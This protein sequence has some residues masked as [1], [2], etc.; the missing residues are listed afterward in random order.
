M[1]LS[2]GQI[3]KLIFCPLNWA[4]NNNVSHKG[5]GVSALNTCRVLRT[6]GIDATVYAVIDYKNLV[7][8]I[9]KVSP[10]HVVINALWLPLAQLSQLIVDYP[11]IHF[12][13]LSHSNIAFLGAHDITLLKQYIDLE[14]ASIGNFNVAANSESG[15][16]GLENSLECPTTYLPNLYY[17]DYTVRQNRNKWQGGTLRIGAYGALRILKNTK[18]AA[19]AALAIANNLGTDLEFHINSGRNDGGQALGIIQAIKNIFSGLPNAKLIL[20]GWNE[21]ASFR[22][23]VRSMHLLLQP[24]YTET[25]N[26][27]TADGVAEGIASVVSPAIGWVPKYW[28]ADPESTED[29]ARVGTLL[30]NYR[31]TGVD[32]F[33]SLTKYNELGIDTW[34]S[35]L[36]NKII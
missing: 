11:N 20:D 10:T 7:S 30:L 26:I 12:A 6:R 34:I 22:Q 27:V 28:K 8:V 31:N 13:A 4:G 17:L 5:L 14:L 21:W 9:S 3:V 24:S 23:L 32:G 25:F 1:I 16:V 15:A 35:W 19:F 33:N 18:S 29:I 36:Q 2:N